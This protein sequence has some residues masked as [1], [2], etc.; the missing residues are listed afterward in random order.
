[1]S[2]EQRAVATPNQVAEPNLFD[3]TGPIV[4]NYSANSI[5]GVPPFS[6]KDA[7]RDLQFRGNEVVR[8]RTNLRCVIVILGISLGIACS[9]VSAYAGGGNILPPTA[10]PLGL[11]LKDMAKALA[12]FYTSNNDPKYLEPPN[13]FPPPRFQVLYAD[14]A[15]PAVRAPR[16]PQPGREGCRVKA[17][18]GNKRPVAG[19][20][21]SRKL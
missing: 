20:G 10:N 13:F 3:I 18:A 19:R 6:Y 15:D 11:S 5:A 17:R 14:R 1:M 2:Q 12:Y 21:C 7:E 8:Y 4:I 16:P 9:A